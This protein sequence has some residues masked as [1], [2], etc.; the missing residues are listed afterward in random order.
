MQ[1]PA[2]RIANTMKSIIRRI[3]RDE[4]LGI[5]QN[6]YKIYSNQIELRVIEICCIYSIIPSHAVGISEDN[7]KQIDK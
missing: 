6:I 3:E 2:D 1:L 7:I 5:T 4:R